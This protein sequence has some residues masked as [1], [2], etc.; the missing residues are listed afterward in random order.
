M[1]VKS[2]NFKLFFANMLF[3]WKFCKL[4]GQSF[5]NSDPRWHCLSYS[6]CSR[7]TEAIA[8]QNPITI[9]F[10]TS[11]LWET[12]FVTDLCLDIKPMTTTLW[13]WSC[14]Q[15]LVHWTVHASNPYLSNLERRILWGT[16]SKALL[17]SR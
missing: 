15:F 8:T 7:D 2:S 13:V 10:W 9:I 16:M 5:E 1:L 14:N 12:P 6:Y 4:L 3:T 17:K 11:D